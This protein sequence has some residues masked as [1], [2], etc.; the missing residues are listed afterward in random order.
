MQCNVCGRE[1]DE[2]EMEFLDVPSDAETVTCTACQLTPMVVAMG[3]PLPDAER[4][5]R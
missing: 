4:G 2:D 1:L 3:V 5:R